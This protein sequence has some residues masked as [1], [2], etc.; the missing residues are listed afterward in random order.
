[1]IR[2]A[3]PRCGAV[4]ESPDDAAGTKLACPECLHR[5]QVPSAPGSR[6]FLNANLLCLLVIF[7]LVI[8]SHVFAV[9]CLGES[10]SSMLSGL[11]GSI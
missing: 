3:C 7:S 1:M 9:S 4:H 11:A 2:Y 6:A 10:I 8:F 5:L